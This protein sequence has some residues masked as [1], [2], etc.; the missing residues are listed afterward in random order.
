MINIAIDGPSGS[1]KSTLAK[2]I[3]K[4]LGYI[5]VDTG[6]LYR[7]IGLY[8]QEHHIDPKQKEAVITVLPDIHLELTYEEGKQ[9]VYVNGTNV[10][11]RIRTPKIAE[12]T[13]IIAS[14]PEVR[15]FL[16]S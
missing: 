14:I 4:R 3:A 6:A 9:T 2:K 8:M 1:G 16:L 7:S 12:I 13:S 10:G 15:A 11:D 5:Y